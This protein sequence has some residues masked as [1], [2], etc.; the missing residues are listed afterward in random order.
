MNAA[1]VRPATEIAAYRLFSK[2]VCA[3][4][5]EQ[6][7]PGPPTCVPD[8]TPPTPPHIVEPIDLALV[9]GE[10]K[11]IS[12]QEKG[13]WAA[14]L[15]RG[16]AVDLGPSIA[17]TPRLRPTTTV[18]GQTTGHPPDVAGERGSSLSRSMGNTFLTAVQHPDVDKNQQ[19]E[20]SRR[21]SNNNAVAAT[22]PAVTEDESSSA[23]GHGGMDGSPA[24]TFNGIDA[25]GENHAKCG[26][27][28]ARRKE[29]GGE[30]ATAGEA[31]RV[32]VE[33]GA[34]RGPGRL[35][36]GDRSPSDSFDKPGVAL[37]S[38]R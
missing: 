1:D 15:S 17:S 10:Q 38:A 2:N 14:E 8:A 35:W 28:S 24:Q 12:A 6:M 5:E 36:D 3:E 19:K 11:R 18:E 25:Q 16:R 32:E 9:G 7:N 37:T 30:T 13:D 34:R 21:E 31:S 27:V 29:A 20:L 23:D 4:I 33:S 22:Q 26:D